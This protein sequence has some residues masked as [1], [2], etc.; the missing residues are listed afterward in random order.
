[1]I[2]TFLQP[3]RASGKPATPDGRVGIG[4][5]GST[6]VAL[7]LCYSLCVVAFADADRTESAKPSDAGDYRRKIPGSNVSF[8]MVAIQGGVFEIGSPEGEAGRHSDEGPQ[9]NVA[10]APFWMGAHEVTWAEYQSYLEL[11]NVFDR[12]ND[13]GIRQI[14]DADRVDA[15]TAP[16]KLYDPSFTYETGD[17]PRQPAVSMSQYAA[18]QYT[19]WLSLLLG[20]FYRLPTEAEWEYAC[21]AGSVTA[22][23]FGDDA[24]QLDDY[25]WHFGNTDYATGK[26]GQKKPNAWGLYDMHGNVSEWVLDAYDPNAYAEAGQLPQPVELVHWPTELYPRVVRGGSWDSEPEDCR[27]AR[28]FASDDDE[29]RTY[30]P[31]YPQS[32]W[33]LA[34]EAGQ[35]VGFRIVRPRDPPPRAEWSKFWDADLDSIQED[36]DRRIDEEGRG[37]RGLVDPSLIDAIKQLPPST[38]S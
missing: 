1:M 28:R 2:F 20:E 33:W 9:L 31:N 34:S 26:V 18:K 11:C 24:G 35:T 22:Y 30:D 14:A 12:F 29:W 25:A 32:P 10:I 13:L 3:C 6:T 16:S 23:C 37:E 17:D 21:R 4:K 38:G 36:V 5:G 8:E 7:L 15:V 19:K 27:S